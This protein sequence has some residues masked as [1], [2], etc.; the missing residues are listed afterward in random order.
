MELPDLEPTLGAVIETDRGSL[1]FSLIHGES[2][3]ACAAWALGDAGV[4]LVDFATS[5]AALSEA[6]EP[7]VLHD[8]LCPMTPAWFIATAAAQSA[9]SGSVVVG[10][11]P[12]TDTVKSLSEGM[13]GQTIDRDGLW[14]VTSP[15]VLPPEVV[16]AIGEGL[17]TT[18]FAELVG[19]LSFAGFTVET[20]EAPPEGRRVATPDDVRLLEAL[21]AG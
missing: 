11:R 7:L 16:E 3:I 6:D 21:T 8:V 14:Q 10:V 1:P 2:L 9:S 13:V 19:H 18:D 20:V 17:P 12:V 15:L 5:W 4:Q